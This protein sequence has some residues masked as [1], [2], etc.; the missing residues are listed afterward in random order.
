MLRSL[1][2]AAAACGEEV[3]RLVVDD[4]ESRGLSWARNCGLDRATGDVVFFADADD[5][6]RPGYFGGLLKLLEASRA[7]FVISSF[8]YAPLKRAYDL[9]GNATVRAALLPAFFGYS[10]EDVRRWNRGG[11]L[12]ARR[13][14]GG[15]WR[16]AFR[17]EFLERHRLRFDEGLFLYEDAPFLAECAGYAARV[18]STDEVFYD[19]APGV[20]GI[21]AS[22]PRGSD[23]YVRYK[24]AALK[25]RKAIA[26]RIGAEVLEQ[27]RG[28]AVLSALEFLSRG[29]LGELR[30]YLADDWVRESVRRFPLSCRHPLVASAVL[31]LKSTL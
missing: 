18:A 30:R 22:S 16:C 13:E 10:L 26:G 24:F 29:R 27:F 3:E 12:A 17:R 20:G 19:Y 14:Q 9:V 21:L 1:D 31:L 23:A 5:T 6:V 25:N 8:D 7:D 15:V 28:S 4:N 11:E 2:A